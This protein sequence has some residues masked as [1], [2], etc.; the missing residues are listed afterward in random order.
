MF[1]RS[2]QSNI[3]YNVIQLKKVVD[4]FVHPR[5]VL[6]PSGKATGSM[7]WFDHPYHIE[8]V[9][10]GG[11]GRRKLAAQREALGCK[12]MKGSLSTE[13]QTVFA[14]LEELVPSGEIAVVV[15]DFSKFFSRLKARI[16]FKTTKT[17]IVVIGEQIFRCLPTKEDF[18]IALQLE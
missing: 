14:Q 4:V 3:N 13:E 12:E 6:G 2:F 16:R 8:T 18:R 11:T 17:P 5:D 9:T 10:D 15:H 1:L 7:T